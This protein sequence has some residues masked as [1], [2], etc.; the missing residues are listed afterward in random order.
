MFLFDT[1]TILVVRPSDHPADPQYLYRQHYFECVDLI[2]CFINSR[3]DQPS[4]RTFTTLESLLLKSTR[5][6][7]YS[8]A[9]EVCVKF[10]P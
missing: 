8:E 5:K 3:C 7:D 1:G 9:I 6:R 2:T 4:H 10:L